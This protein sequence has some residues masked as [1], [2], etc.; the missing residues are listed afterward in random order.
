MQRFPHAFS[1]GQRQR[2]GIARALVLHPAPGGGRRAGVGAGRF[3]AGTGAQLAAGTARRAPPDLSLCGAQ[4]ERRQAHL[5][6]RGS[7]VRGQTRRDGQDAEIFNAPKH[8]YTAALMAA[9]PV[10]DPRGVGDVELKGEVPSPANP[11]AAA[12]SIRAALSQWRCAG[13]R[14]R[15]CARSRRSISSVAIAPTSCTLKGLVGT[16]KHA[17]ELRSAPCPFESSRPTRS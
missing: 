3:G 12:T 2:I 1:G 16:W 10:A 14:R 17:K 7:D 9:V 11:P 4:S 13:Q 6:P 8:P 15:L 5:R